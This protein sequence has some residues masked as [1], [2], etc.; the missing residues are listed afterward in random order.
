MQA[1]RKID[2]QIRIENEYDSNYQRTGNAV[3][4]YQDSKKIVTDEK[5][6]N[7]LQRAINK[8]R[9]KLD[10]YAD[11]FEFYARTLPTFRKFLEENNIDLI[12]QEARV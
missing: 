12:S 9:D 6:L 4:K 11:N 5:L 8:N 3:L 2:T 1:L 10:R 7:L